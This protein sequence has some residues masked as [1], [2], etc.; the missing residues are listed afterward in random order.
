MLYYLQNCEASLLQLDKTRVFAVFSFL[1]LGRR[2][3]LPFVCVCLCECICLFHIS[4]TVVLLLIAI[5]AVIT[6]L[7]EASKCVAVVLLL[8]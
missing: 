3:A 7:L 1:G 4:I 8:F 2:D 5:K 6:L